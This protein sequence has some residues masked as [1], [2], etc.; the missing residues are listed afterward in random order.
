MS[1][2]IAADDPTADDV[3]AVLARHLAFAHEVTPP[4]GVHALGVD[5]LAGPDI[6]FFSA[7]IDGRVVGVGALKELDATH[8]EL[9]SLHTVEEARGRGVGRA[10]VAH[11]LTAAAERRYGRVSLETGVMDAF[12]PARALYAAMGFVPCPPFGEYASSPTSACMTRAMDG[13]GDPPAVGPPA[14][15]SP[16]GAATPG[17][18]GSPEA[19]ATPGGRAGRRQG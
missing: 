13:P 4:E 10:L 19:A 15:T 17:D 18:A 11:L 1:L 2:H 6:T 8:A 7:R 3:R 14:T 5:G 16:E 9:K 12:A